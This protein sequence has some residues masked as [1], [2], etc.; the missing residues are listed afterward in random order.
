MKGFDRALL[1]KRVWLSAS[2]L[3]DYFIVVLTPVLRLTILSWTT[4]NWQTVST[5]V[6]STLVGLGVTGTA[7]D[8]T[9]L[10]LGFAL[11][12]TLFV[13]DDFLRWLVH[14]YFHVIPE[15]W[16]FHKVHH[17]AEVLNFVTADRQHPVEVIATATVLSL[18]YGLV[19]GLFIGLFGDN[20]TVMTVAGAN[21]FLFF[22]NIIGGV[23][24]H[25]PFWISFG[26]KV[27]RWVISPAMHQIHHSEDPK[28]FDR[29]MGG[30]LAVW[31]RIFGTLYVP[32][33]HEHITFG[34][35]VETEDFRQLGV[36]YGRPF[37]AAADHLKKRF[38]KAEKQASAKPV[39]V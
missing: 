26:P 18:A 39:S 3:N 33:E 14:Y 36:I 13:V 21:I 2:A 31:D 11:T 23:L 19:N 30:S 4:L 9:A 38:G 6:S 34:I 27:E 32:T 17:T 8:G 24:R 12:L 28:H 10:M 37:T 35:G 1:D 29:N 7:T 20:L 5:W 15:L 25:S 16:E 22:F